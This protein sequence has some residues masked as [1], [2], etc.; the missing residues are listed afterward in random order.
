MP[1]SLQS[2]LSHL[3]FAFSESVLDAIRGASIEELFGDP[4]GTRRAPRRSAAAPR[5]VAAPVVAAPERGPR[6]RGGRLP[7]RS[8]G[9]IAHVVGEIVTLLAA[10]PGGLRAEQIRKKLGLQAKELPRPLHEAVESGRLGKSGQKRATTYFV[11]GGAKAAAPAKGP[12]ASRARKTAAGGRR[13]VPRAAAKVAKKAVPAKRG[14][15]SA[16]RA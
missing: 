7:R 16:K 12:A 8:V 10:S 13:R 14:R 1:T 11:K 9:D 15:P 5:A 4:G 3:A 6:R 2:R